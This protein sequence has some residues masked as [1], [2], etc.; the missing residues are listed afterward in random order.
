MNWRKKGKSRCVSAGKE[1]Q[2]HGRPA[3]HTGAAVMAIDESA[4]VKDRGDAVVTAMQGYALAVLLKH[5]PSR[6]GSVHGGTIKAAMSRGW[7][8]ERSAPEIGP[9]A[10]RYHLTNPGRAVAGSS[11][12]VREWLAGW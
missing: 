6:L 11:T 9:W 4:G 12:C 8:E 5:G 3:T 10:T 2:G 1:I 7:I